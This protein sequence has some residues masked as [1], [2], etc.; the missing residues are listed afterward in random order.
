MTPSEAV[1]EARKRIA[2]ARESHLH[3]LD[4]GDLGLEH[5]P[6]E[7]GEL[8]DLRVLALGRVK[9]REGPDRFEWEWDD[10]RPEPRMASVEPLR[11][12]SGLTSLDLG[13]CERLTSVEPLRG[14]SRLTSLDLG[15]CAQL[16]S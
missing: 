2:I 1:A 9:L 12:L 3:W 15:G 7:I 8:S 14:L 6:P 5:I 11:G 13:G 16:T 4:L 10:T